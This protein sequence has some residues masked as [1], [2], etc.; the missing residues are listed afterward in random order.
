MRESIAAER[1]WERINPVFSGAGLLNSSLYRGRTMLAC[2]PQVKQSVGRKSVAQFDCTE[3]L[4]LFEFFQ[5]ID[6][7]SA[8]VFYV[9]LVEGNSIL[10]GV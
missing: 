5:N 3:L 8:S 1:G 4:Q 6:A 2:E 7:G 9:F 10:Y